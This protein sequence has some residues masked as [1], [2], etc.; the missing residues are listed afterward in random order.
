MPIIELAKALKTHP[1]VE[2]WADDPAAWG[3]GDAFVE[4]TGRGLA[5]Q[6]ERAGPLRAVGR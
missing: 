6:G 3:D 4:A 1:E 5:L 2:L